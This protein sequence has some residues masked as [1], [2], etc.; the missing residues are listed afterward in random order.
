MG[1]PQYNRVTAHEGKY[2]FLH[3]NETQLQVCFH[4]RADAPQLRRSFCINP[5]HR[6]E[7]DT[8]FALTAARDLL[9][10][11]NNHYIIASDKRKLPAMIA[12]LESCEQRDTLGGYQAELVEVEA[13]IEKQTKRAAFLKAVIEE[14]CIAAVTF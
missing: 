13:A 8:S 2:D 9:R 11:L 1:T 12:Y 6:G 10:C 5:E 4:L 3:P 7:I 14:M